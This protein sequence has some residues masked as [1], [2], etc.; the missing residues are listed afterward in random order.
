[1]KRLSLALLLALGFGAAPA[2]AADTG[3]YAGAGIGI[4]NTEISESDIGLK[5]DEDD[6]GF[7]VFGG[8]QFLPWLGAELAYIDGG[9]SSVSTSDPAFGSAKLEVDV[10][11]ITAAAVG[12]LPIGE[13]FE[14]YGKLGIAMWDGKLTASASGLICEELELGETCAE[15]VSDDGTD[16][17]WGIGA[18]INIGEQFN[19]RVEYEV[20]E[21]DPQGVN[22][23]TDFLS[24]SGVYRF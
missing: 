10:S 23:D 16:F 3:F 12:T 19:V 17:F 14:L 8:Y 2:I 15:S 13:M 1:M 6:T 9:E 5:F 11:A 18:G 24:L 4:F 7:K 21:I 20:L 22:A